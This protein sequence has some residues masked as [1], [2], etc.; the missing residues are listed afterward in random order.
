MK[1]TTV[2]G[3]L[4]TAPLRSLSLLS[5]GIVSA[6]DFSRENTSASKGSVLHDPTG[7][8]ATA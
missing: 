6:P 7:M 2:V 4:R 3:L 5:M 1:N 8:E